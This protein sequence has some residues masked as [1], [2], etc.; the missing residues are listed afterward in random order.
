MNDHSQF[1][2]LVIQQTLSLA[3]RAPS[4]PRDAAQGSNVSRSSAEHCSQL[5]A[6][7]HGEDGPLGEEAIDTSSPSSATWDHAPPLSP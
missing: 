4:P 2:V 3:L 6:P 7:M 1:Y 5:S